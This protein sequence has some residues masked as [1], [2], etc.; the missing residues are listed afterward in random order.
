MSRS[1]APPG[2]SQ[3]HP[4]L[5]GCFL[6]RSPARAAR[7]WDLGPIPIRAYA[8]CIIAGIVVGDL[9]RRAALGGARRATRHGLGHRGL[10][11]PLRAGRRP[12]LPRDHRQRAVLPAPGGD[13][14]RAFYVWE[15]GLGIWGAIAL[16]GVGAWI[17][18]RRRG[19]QA[20]AVRGRVRARDRGRA[21][22]RPVGQLLQPGAVRR[23]RP[24]CRGRLRIDPAPAE[25]G[26]G[27]DRLPPHV[28]VRVAVGLRPGGVL[29]SGSTGGSRWAAGGS[30]P[31][32]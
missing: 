10:G 26:A 2:R 13:P 12:A 19:D 1:P 4:R 6:R 3:R 8:L 7:V 20:A 18:C 15:G 24:T 23:G 31:C 25:H 30:S 27:R 21:G 28:P 29:V 11:G 5:G 9:D 22:D 17:G 14:W 32:T 16:G